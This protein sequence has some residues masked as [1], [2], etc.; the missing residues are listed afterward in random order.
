MRGGQT[1]TEQIGVGGLQEMGRKG[2][3]SSSGVSGGEGAQEEGGP[4][5]ESQV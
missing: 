5:D 1:R 2:G 3:F 4:V